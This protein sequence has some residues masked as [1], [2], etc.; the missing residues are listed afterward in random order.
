MGYFLEEGS[1]LVDPDSETRSSILSQIPKD[2]MDFPIEDLH[3]VQPNITAE[4][5]GET[6][7]FKGSCK[8]LFKYSGTVGSMSVSGSCRGTYIGALVLQICKGVGKYSMNEEGPFGQHETNS[9]CKGSKVYSPL[10][11]EIKE[12]KLVGYTVSCAGS[13]SYK[14]E[15]NFFDSDSPLLDGYKRNPRN[16]HL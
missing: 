6:A 4:C 5:N 12:H 13:A 7:D 2:E 15:F 3:D 10:V 16:L 8:G 1:S 11:L 14:S 9:V